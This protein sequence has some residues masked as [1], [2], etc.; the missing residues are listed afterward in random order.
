MSEQDRY[1]RDRS[2]GIS[3]KLNQPQTLLVFNS[4]RSPILLTPQSQAIAGGRRDKQPHKGRTA[5][6]VPIPGQIRVVVA[7]PAADDSIA[8]SLLHYFGRSP[9]VLRPAVRRCEAH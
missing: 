6:S 8:V 1:Q 5:V 2:S 7:N 3:S 9:A 4:S